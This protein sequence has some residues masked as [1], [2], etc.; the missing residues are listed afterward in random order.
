MAVTTTNLIQGAGDL[1]SAAFG[2]TEPVDTAFSTAPDSPFVDCGGTQDGVTLTIKQ[3]YAAL[4]VDQIVDTPERR[5]TSREFTVATNLAEVTLANLTLALNSYVTASSGGSGGTAYSSLTAASSSPGGTGPTYAALIFDGY[6]E[7]ARRRRFTG[8]KMLQTGDI[9]QA[10]TKDKQTLL[11]VSF[12]GH[13]VSP[14]ILPFK[15][16]QD[17]E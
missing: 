5:L 3:E 14:S 4:S 10:Y 6:G 16:V 2:S 7:G 8:R 9:G 13:Y 1:Y 11:P 12:V 17:S 15:I